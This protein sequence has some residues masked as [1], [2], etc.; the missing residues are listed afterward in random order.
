[1]EL[2]D[3]SKKDFEATRKQIKVKLDLKQNQICIVECICQE[4]IVLSR[5]RE[6]END[7]S[8]AGIST[9]RKMKR[10]YEP[11]KGVHIIADT[12][13]QPSKVIA[14]M[15]AA[16]Y[17]YNKRRKAYGFTQTAKSSFKLS[18]KTCLPSQSF[19]SQVGRNAHLMDISHWIV[20]I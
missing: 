7:Y 12:S 18:E 19:K 1:M 14:K 9:Y 5:L 3:D 10:I 4:D 20:C 11:V 8:D 17:Y 16:K 6:R 13:E 15:V 2:K